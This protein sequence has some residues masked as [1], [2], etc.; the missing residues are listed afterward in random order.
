VKRRLLIKTLR[1][2]AKEA[3]VDFTLLRNGANHDIYLLGSAKVVV[4]RHTEIN[5]LTA[6]G[7][8]KDASDH[9]RGGSK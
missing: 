9:V 4:P 2:L 3:D 6:R 7:I 8:I 1:S 5:E